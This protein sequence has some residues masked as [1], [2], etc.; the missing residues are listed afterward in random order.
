MTQDII[1]R[2]DDWFSARCG[3]LGAS[4]IADALAKTRSGYSASRANLRAKLVLERLTGKQEDG[5]KSA[6]MQFGIDNEE[7]ARSAYQFLMNASVQEVGLY[8]HPSINWTHASPD[9][10]VGERGLLEIK[11]PQPATHLETLKSQTIADRYIKQMYWQMTCTGRDWCDFVSFQPSF[12]E[13]LQFFCKRIERDDKVIAD[14]ESQVAEFLAE[15]EADLDA[16]NALRV[17]A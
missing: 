12:P 5:F 16:L 9:G 2:S 4:Q 13:D 17:A 15:V 6:A 3:S 10:L 14:L 7:H 11:V 8:K 1:Q